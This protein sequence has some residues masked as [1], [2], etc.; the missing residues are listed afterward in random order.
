MEMAIGGFEIGRAWIKPSD[1]EDV[2]DVVQKMYVEG[3]RL[4][5]IGPDGAAWLE[6]PK[7][8]PVPG[9]VTYEQDGGRKLQS[10]G[11]PCAKCGS[12]V[13]KVAGVSGIVDIRCVACGDPAPVENIPDEEGGGVCPSCRSA[14]VL[15]TEFG[16][17]CEGCSAQWDTKGGVP[18]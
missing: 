6:R 13:F 12:R 15:K 10:T 1:Q 18:R 9:M 8:V 7:M 14:D 2:F 17:R 3:W 16:W 11:V 5:S 4:I